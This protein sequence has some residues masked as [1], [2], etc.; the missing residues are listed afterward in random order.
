MRTER[1]SV[2]APLPGDASFFITLWR[3]SRVMA[4]VG[5]PR[6]LVCDEEQT[7]RRISEENGKKSIFGRPLLIRLAVC[8]SSHTSPRGKPT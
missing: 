2:E 3:D 1:L 8:S 6:G 4:H 7:A 5:F